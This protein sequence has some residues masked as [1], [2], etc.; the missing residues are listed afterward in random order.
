MSKPSSGAEFRPDIQGLRALAVGIVMLAHAGFDR[1][2]GGFIGVD[3]FFVISGFLII[4]LLV[5][6]AERTSRVSILGFY[7]RRA[8]R[9]LPA[10]TVVLVAC[11]AVAAWVLPYVRGIEV[12]KDTV[13]SAF[14]LANVRFASVETDYF[15]AGEPPSIVQ[16]YWSLA[17]EEQFYLVIPL[18][19][20]AVAALH[21]R[22]NRAGAPTDPAGAPAAGGPATGAG[23]LRRQLAVVLVA[24]VALSLAWSVYATADNPSAAYFSTLARA[25]ELAAGGLLAVLVWGRR[26]PAGRWVADGLALA[27]LAL[28]VWGTLTFSGATAFPGIAAAVP[29]LGSLLLLAAGATTGGSDSLIGRLLACPPARVVGDWSYSLYL[30][31]FPVFRA[32]VAEWGPLDRVQVLAAVVV[33]FALAGATYHLIEQPFRKRG[34]WRR[35]GRAIALY[36][37]SVALVVVAAVGANAAIQHQIDASADNPSIELG[38]YRK[39]EL[40]KDPAVALVEASV[41][42]AEEDRAVPGQLDPPLGEVRDSIAP[43]G[44]CD[45]R[46]GTQDLCAFGTADADRSIVVLGDSHGRAWGPTFTTIGERYGYAVYQLVLSGCPANQGTRSDP[47]NGGEWEFCA[48]FNDWTVEQVAQLQPDVVVIANNAYSQGSFKEIQMQGLADQV[49]A[50]REVTDRVVLVGDTPRLPAMPGVC[51]STRDVDLGDCLFAPAPGQIKKQKEFGAITR[52]NGG[53]Y[54]DALDWFCSRRKCPSVIGDIV[55]LR[56]KDHIST[57]YAEKLAGPVAKRLGLDE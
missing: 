27:G 7:A 14:F 29:V 10:A 57:P 1:F 30:W 20:M 19:I 50:L 28:I 18:V 53:E 3:V 12:V 24:V 44:D 37:A 2:A 34:T 49:T 13:W 26:V 5:A 21:R 16:H 51:L 15:A 23:G 42:A 31:H 32:A 38:D 41:I 40:S 43:L 6:E 47:E 56:D 9:V 35:V 33:T 11:A 55:P 17:V 36:P 46:T 22:R 4:G 8:R 48:D 54:L 25:W 45:Y 39:G 52:D